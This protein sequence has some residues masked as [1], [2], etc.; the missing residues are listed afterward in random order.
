MSSPHLCVTKSH[1]SIAPRT[2]LQLSPIGERRI[3][4]WPV[5]LRASSADTLALRG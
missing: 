3:D 4:S 5:L 2:G 1:R